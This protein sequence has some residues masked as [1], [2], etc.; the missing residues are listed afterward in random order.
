MRWKDEDGQAIILVALGM[1]IF[2][3]AAIGFAVDGAHLYAQ[4]QMAQTAA[5]AAAQAGVMSIFEGTNGSGTAAFSTSST[6]T[7]STTDAK[8]P[9]VY[10]SQNGFG[11]TTADGVTID[12]PGAAAAPG[13]ALANDFP[14][15][16]VRATVTRNVNTTILRLLGPTVTQIKAVAV[17]AITSVVAPVPILVMHP[18]LTGA[19]S[20]N[21]GPLITICG[22]PHRSIQVN[23]NDPNS[24][25]SN[26]AKGTIDL[27]HAGPP[28][29]GDCST[30]TGADFG[31][32]GG[33]SS[34]A[35]TFKGGS[36]GTYQQPAPP[37]PD[38]L[39]SVPVPSVPSAAPAPVA[40]AN[41]VSGCPIGS[42][43]QC[44]LYA[45]GAYPSGL[46][47]KNQAAIMES[48]IYYLQ[49]NG[50]SCQANCDMY[51]ATGY[52][53][54]Y[55]DP[56]SGT[57]ST[58][59]SNVMFYNTGPLVGGFANAGSFQV[60][61]NGNITLTGSPPDSPFKGIL[62]FQDRNSVANTGKN[63]HSLGGGGGLTLVGTI[64]ITNK[65]G[66]MLADSKHYQE[67]DLQGTP[68][69]ATTVQ[70]E[71]IVGTLSLG[72]NAGI[73]MNLNSKAV[74]TVDEVALVN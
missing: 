54:T 46:V 11:G 52:P 31:D 34:P 63:A 7:C 58:W 48:G 27:S 16:V 19:L 40:I 51:M 61:A 71:I 33:P 26:G 64:Y 14:V 73:T 39:L 38:P 42:K 1:S 12:F 32:F 4:R 8:T 74:I 10:A 28:D 41:G 9:C 17:A 70:G 43:K 23:S 47:L 25:A 56:T 69:S 50:L 65:K 37:L 59:S 30:G 45:P 67:V 62:F 6:F 68:G 20:T 13:V 53:F 29:P 36:T 15:N 18:T 24:S 21:G 55:T 3:L 5:D 57:T 44:Y 60:G 72:G 66:T 2:L 49:S 22:G 35:F